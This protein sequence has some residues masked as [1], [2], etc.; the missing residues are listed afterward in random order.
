MSD[1]IVER[2][3]LSE[4]SYE[5]CAVHLE[6]ERSQGPAYSLAPNTIQMTVN[7]ELVSM[8]MDLYDEKNKTF[9]HFVVGLLEVNNVL[10]LSEQRFRNLLSVQKKVVF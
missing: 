10:G 9:Y 8:R 4:S 7:S 2:M 3:I 6:P 5:G 1:G